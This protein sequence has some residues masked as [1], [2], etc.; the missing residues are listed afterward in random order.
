MMARL[1]LAGALLIALAAG[2]G[3]AADEN[4]Q[5]VGDMRYGSANYQLVL[6]SAGHFAIKVGGSW[7][8]GC[9]CLNV[10]SVAQYQTDQLSHMEGRAEA[11]PGGR[12]ITVSGRLTP[13]VAFTETLVCVDQSVTLTYA[14]QALRDLPHGDIRLTAGPQTDQM[15]GHVVELTT[16]PG[17]QQLAWPPAQPLQVQGVQS[18]NWRNVGLREARTV[19]VK[20]AASQVNLSDKGATYIAWLRQAGPMKQGTTAEATLRFEAV[21]IGDAAATVANVTGKLAVTKFSL[22]GTNGLLNNVRTDQGLLIQQLSINEQ[23]MHQVMIGQGQGSEWGGVRVGKQEPGREYLVEGKGPV[24]NEWQ[25]K[26]GARSTSA[27]K[28]EIHWVAHRTLDQGPQRLRVLMYVAQWLEQERN[29]YLIRTPDGKLQTQDAGETLWFGMPPQSDD[30]GLGRYRRLGNYPAGTEIVVPMLAR[31]EQM[32]VRL[33][34]PME[35]DGFRFE[36]YFRGLWFEALDNKQQDLDLTVTVEK[37]PQRQ[38]GTLQVAE[39]PLT[40]AVKLG[41]GGIPLLDGLVARDAKGQMVKGSWDW[42]AETNGGQGTLGAQAKSVEMRVPE[43]LWGKQLV[44]YRAKGRS[45]TV[46]A[47]RLTRLG[48]DLPP[49][50]L[51]AG[52]RLEFAPTALERVEIGTGGPVSLRLS[53]LAGTARLTLT[54][55]S[56]ALKLK[57]S[58]RQITPAPG[59][60]P[61]QS[62][63]RPRPLPD[64]PGVYGGLAVKKDTPARGDVTIATPWWEVRHSA[65]RGGAITSVRF[66]NGTGQSILTAP[67][68][69][70]LLTAEGAF[71]DLGD[72]KPTLT[73]EQATPAFVRVKVTGWLKTGQGKPLC[74]FEHSSAGE[75]VSRTLLRDPG[76]PGRVGVRGV[77]HDCL[78]VRNGPGPQA[79][80]VAMATGVSIFAT[81]L[82]ATALVA[83]RLAAQGLSPLG[84]RSPR[85]P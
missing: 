36:I 47:G 34:Q 55:T 64:D 10:D 41:S 15:Q 42:R 8:P 20:C 84:T 6:W 4:S 71:T 21:P 25:E 18:V 37:L 23:D 7:M 2:A 78:R 12:K 79:E 19:F 60:L 54:A 58:H 43:Y 66:L 30:P 44:L 11:I 62:R 74:P 16:A 13:D 80:P 51:P 81:L 85:S 53:Q 83:V 35:I 24:I 70:R 67:V 1:T 75:A 57:L 46:L 39:D 5:T 52:S 76:E 45:H 26:I 72:G 77:Y 38:A 3:L 14:V 56:G 50:E 61:R 59:P 63:Q 65:A 22:S 32:T 33:G 69:T 28:D 9:V 31:G 68:A 82:A 17:R 49:G 48:A 40:G 27:G 29:P 73:V